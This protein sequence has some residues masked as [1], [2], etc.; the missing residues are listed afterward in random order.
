M[1]TTTK[2]IMAVTLVAALALVGGLGS[3][4][5]AQQQSD[6][7]AQDRDAAQPRTDALAEDQDV[8][9]ETF[10][11][12]I[13]DV[14]AYLTGPEN[15]EADAGLERK[16]LWSNGDSDHPIALVSERGFLGQ[17]LQSKRV[18]LIIF[19]PEKPESQE[20]YEKARTLID[21]HVQLIGEVYD[22]DGL[23]AV[24]V[25]SVEIASPE[26]ASDAEPEADDAQQQPWQDSQQDD[27]TY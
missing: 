8:Q 23:Q 27:R 25:R 6:P 24:S 18:H 1:L 3:S 12:R 26:P 13:V 2:W 11:G 4:T 17:M 21:Q 22:R 10:H 15:A 7:G 5:F 14:R 16:E 9:P 19:N 20:A